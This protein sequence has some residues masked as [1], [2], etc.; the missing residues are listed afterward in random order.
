[1]VGAIK[2][3]AVHPTNRDIVYVGGINGGVWRTTNATAARPHWDSLT[4]NEGSLSIG[5]LQ[6][7]PTD[8]SCRTIV[9][10]TGRFS[11]LNRM[12][13]G[14]IGLLRS[15]DDGN[16]WTTLDGGGVLKGLHICGVAPRGSTIV[17]AAN[18]GGLF[19]SIDTGVTWQALTGTP[20]TGLPAGTSFA[21]ASDP[22][23]PTRLYAHVG[24]SGIYRSTD[25]GATWSKVSNAAIGALLTA[26]TV[27]V[28]ISV[29]FHDNVYVAIAGGRQLTGLFRSGNGGSTWTALDLP[30]T[31]EVGGVVFGI[32]PGGQASIHLS[33]AADRDSENVVYIG[34]DRQVGSDEAIGSAPPWPNAIGATDYSGRIFRVDASRP[35]GSQATHMT[36]TNTASRSAPHADSRD[37]AV[38]P[39]GDL[40][41]TDD[42]GIYRRTDPLSNTGDWLSMNGDLQI[43]EFHSAV[44]DPGT[45]TLLG[46]AQDTGTPQ[47][48]APAGVAWG[49]VSTGDGGA[50]LAGHTAPGFST[51]YSSYNRL[52]D[53]RREVF[54]AAGVLQ[55]RTVVSLVVVGGGSPLLPE[56]YTPIELNQADPTRLILGAANSVYESDD[57]GDTIVEVGPGIQVNAGLPTT[58]ASPIAY[59]SA[60]NPDLL[61]VG[62]ANDVFVRTAAHPSPL[63]ASPSY[64]STG[65]VAGIAVPSAEPQTAYV[66]EAAKVY[67]T[68]DAGGSWTDIT[69]GLLAL[70]GAVLHCVTYCPDLDGGSVVVGTNAGV[71]AAAGPGFTW[72][73]LGAGLPA[74][75]VLRLKYLA[76]DRVMAAGTLGRGLWTLDIPEPAIV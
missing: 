75:P 73:K 32:H 49:S 26:G 22:S 23:D 20:G 53:F 34:G 15:T 54:D 43:A 41:E 74:A 13:G 70:G 50:V 37:M 6:L 62:A 46:G 1:M 67:R 25:T 66:V 30:S 19:R 76:S 11:S 65:A 58:Y 60:A 27:N 64:P 71:F 28:K 42:G 7:D 44:W 56:F 69:G 72:S 63:T 55:S 5:A 2:A 9:A 12:G 8:V 21:L 10:G 39:N 40:L 59:G 29:G 57:E 17:I 24:T 16:T 48:V 3:V 47:Q 38:D 31:L 68:S 51:R 14:L 4:D 33:L 52:F 35:E 36:H 45:R 61:Y 18:N